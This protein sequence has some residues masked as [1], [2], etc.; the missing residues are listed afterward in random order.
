MNNK[1]AYNA[2]LSSIRQTT[3]YYLSLKKQLSAQQDINNI[4]Q[5]ESLLQCEYAKWTSSAQIPEEIKT[6]TNPQHYPSLFCIYQKAI[7]PLG[8]SQKLDT[9]QKL[10]DY[11]VQLY[12]VTFHQ[13]LSVSSIILNEHFADY[14]HALYQYL[15]FHILPPYWKFLQS[16]ANQFEIYSLFFYTNNFIC[17]N[18]NI[19]LNQSTIQTSIYQPF[20]CLDK[21]FI[22]QF[23]NETAKR[24]SST[25]FR[26]LHRQLRKNL[27]S[28]QNYK[29]NMNSLP[30]SFNLNINN[31]VYPVQFTSSGIHISEIP[32]PYCAH[33]QNIIRKQELDAL[34][35][36]IPNSCIELLSILSNND[37]NIFIQIS[38]LFALLSGNHFSSLNKSFRKLQIVCLNP[39]CTDVFSKI[40]FLCN[41]TS[42]DINGLNVLSKKQTLANVLL[43]PFMGLNYIQIS[44]R[45]KKETNRQQDIILSLIKGAAIHSYN[46]IGFP[47]ILKNNLPILI[48]S[49]SEKEINQLSS[50]YP[51]EIIRWNFDFEEADRIMSDMSPKTIHFLKIFITLTGLYAYSFCKSTKKKQPDNSIGIND[52]ISCFCQT[53]ECSYIFFDEL[54]NLY[55]E[56]CANNSI[57]PLTFICFNK[58]MKQ[59]YSYKRPHLSRNDNRWA[60][61]NLKF[62][63]DSWNNHVSKPV[64]S[65]NQ[66]YSFKQYLITM[67]QEIFNN[68]QSALS[69]FSPHVF[70]QTSTLFFQF[71]KK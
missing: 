43:Y 56:Y 4:I 65:N 32:L 70:S 54:Y 11:T 63:Y 55:Q 6:I 49:N 3:D 66:P 7:C 51:S 23:Y 29:I 9:P 16:Y 67:H 1:K 48:F 31:N 71:I 30:C 36:S 44:A 42:P 35:K 69:S 37:K 34:F 5:S 13:K 53:K 15:K 40:L 19:Y 50:I 20:S 52:F 21:N 8:T 10:L 45:G 33:K 14:Y 62:D 17:I 24:P 27:S 18:G 64:S 46:D 41:N 47:I 60:Y 58:Q 68:L 26:N 22:Y 28:D 59:H 61:C 12:S 39:K 38:K 2:T 25:F 57:V